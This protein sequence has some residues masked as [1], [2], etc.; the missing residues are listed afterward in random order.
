MKIQQKATIWDDKFKAINS[1]QVVTIPEWM[2]TRMLEVLPPLIMDEVGFLSS[3]P[4]DYNKQGEAVYFAGLKIGKTH[5]GCL[6][7]KK[8]YQS[9]TT[10]KTLVN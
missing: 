8:D 5:Y 6:S 4:F 2:F 3:E 9:R 1:G 10:Y 7:T